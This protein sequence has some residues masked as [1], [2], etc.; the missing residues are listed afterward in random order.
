[1]SEAHFGQHD[2]R[3]ARSWRLRWSSQLGRC[4]P[5][6]CDQKQDPNSSHR[7]IQ[8][9]QPRSN[10][11]IGFLFDLFRSLVWLALMCDKQFTKIMLTNTKTM[12]PRSP[13]CLFKKKVSL[14][15]TKASDP[16][17]CVLFQ[18]MLRASWVWNAPCHYS[19]RSGCKTGNKAKFKEGVLFAIEYPLMAYVSLLRLS[20]FAIAAAL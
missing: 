13:A 14:A 5:S 10:V 3:G 8:R 2:S 12:M 18:R 16:R 20:S 19:T 6:R 15:S 4:Y 7:H 11:S 1:M 17:F 9:H